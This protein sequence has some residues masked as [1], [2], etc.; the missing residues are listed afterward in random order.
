MVHLRKERG[1]EMDKWLSNTT[2][3][4]IKKAVENA[5]EHLGFWIRKGSK[6]ETKAQESF[7]LKLWYHQLQQKYMVYILKIPLYY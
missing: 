6:H 7:I 1:K 5:M 4:E 2:K 3:E